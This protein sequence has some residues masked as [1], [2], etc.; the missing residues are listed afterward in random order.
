[1]SGFI[2]VQLAAGTYVGT[3][4][5]ERTFGAVITSETNFAPN[6][7]SAWHFHVNPHY[8]HILEGGSK[9]LRKEGT[10]R[11]YAGTGLYYHPGIAHQNVNYLPGTRIFNIELTPDFFATYGLSYPPPSLMWGEMMQLNTD[12]LVRIMKEHYL[13]DAASVIAMDQLCVDL[14]APCQ[15]DFRCFPEWTRKIREIMHDHWDTP[16]SLC[17]LS[18]QLDLH[19]VTISR[20]F[21]RYF[22]CS[23]GE[24]LRKIK[25][26]RAIPLI[27]K[28]QASLTRIAYECGFTDQAHFTKTFLRITGLRPNQYRR[29]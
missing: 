18:T 13:N 17:F 16:L 12:G 27:K 6:M 23:A 5:K 8:S 10:D 28:R 4:V 25:V 19:P 15:Q 24:Y 20:Y 3:K 14:V 9:E 21:S 2:P 29:I 7:A 11:Q 26:E 22:G 1:M